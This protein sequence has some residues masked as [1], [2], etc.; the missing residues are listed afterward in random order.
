MSSKTPLPKIDHK[1]YDVQTLHVCE[2]IACFILNKLY[3]EIYLNVKELKTNDKI[4]NLTDGYKQ[5][6]MFFYK[7]LKKPENMKKILLGIHDMFIENPGF[8][9]MTFRDCIHKISDQFT[10]HNDRDGFNEKQKQKIVM[11]VMLD[12]CSNFI[13]HLI[14]NRLGMVID[15]RKQ[16]QNVD[17]LKNEL[18][19]ALLFQRERMLSDYYGV[20][21]GANKTEMPKGFETK[22]KAL[23]SDAIRDKII[24]QKQAKKYY[25]LALKF[26]NELDQLRNT[27]KK[28]YHSQPVPPPDTMGSESDDNQEEDED[29]LEQEDQENEED[30]VPHIEGLTPITPPNSTPVLKPRILQHNQPSQTA[31]VQFSKSV[32]V[33]PVRPKPIKPI[34]P[35]K[36]QPQTQ[37]E[38]ENEL[39]LNDLVDDSDDEIHQKTEPSKKYQKPPTSQTP[40][41]SDQEKEESS[42]EN[43]DDMLD[44]MSS[45]SGRYG[46]ETPP[47]SKEPPKESPKTDELK[48]VE[49]KSVKNE[50]QQKRA[51]PRPA[52]SV[53]PQS[54]TRKPVKKPEVPDDDL[55]N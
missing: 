41:E 31:R 22:L 14:T 15:N 1:Q 39:D 21:V 11:K 13:D 36:P 48:P 40:E 20:V 38:P 23:V 43:L 32:Q 33:Q 17:I 29:G 46:E 30:D 4:P 7:G 6:L 18:I 53:A 51:Q 50:P 12:V 49:K 16:K 42:G 52:I 37:P 45:D 27:N 25:Q 47:P 34:T 9:G 35:I 26:K 54:L 10:P 44:G 3:N 55:F 24:A 8:A 2:V 19:N 5:G 28:V